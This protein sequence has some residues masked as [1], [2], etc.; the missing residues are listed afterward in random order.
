MEQK[1]PGLFQKTIKNNGLRPTSRTTQPIICQLVASSFLLPF[2]SAARFVL[3]GFLFPRMDL[4]LI[5][6]PFTLCTL[7]LR[8]LLIL[9]FF[10][11]SVR[12]ACLWTSL[13]LRFS[14]SS[15]HQILQ[16]CFAGSAILRQFSTLDPAF[17]LRWFYDSLSVQYIRSC[18]SILQVCFANSSILRRF[19][20]RNCTSFPVFRQFFNSLLASWIL[21]R[22][23]LIL[24]FFR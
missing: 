2:L 1:Q 11:S 9:R 22:V 8:T 16:L 7:F 23:S 17:V 5:P 14:V 24:Q 19:H 10:V 4:P 13:V 15:V 6:L 18:F 3:P 21:L 20:F 12:I